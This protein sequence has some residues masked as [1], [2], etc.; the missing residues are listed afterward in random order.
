M[1]R[2]LAIVA[3][4]AMETVRLDAGLAPWT[5]LGLVL[6]AALAQRMAGRVLAELSRVSDEMMAPPGSIPCAG[7]AGEQK[8]D[9]CRGTAVLLVSGF[10]AF[11]VQSLHTLWGAYPRCF[12]QI[13]FLGVLPEDAAASTELS[14]AE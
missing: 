6:L 9:P 12:S 3:P 1:I 7:T 11:G 8:L 4:H 13:L 5:L 2:I 10:N 14:E